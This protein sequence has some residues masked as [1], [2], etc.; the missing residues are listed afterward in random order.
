MLAG[1]GSPGATDG[2]GLAATFNAPGALA[3]V[4]R[5]L[6]VADDGNRALRRL[7][8]DDITAPVTTLATTLTF[9]LGLAAGPDAL[10]ASGA[11]IFKLTPE[12]QATRLAD[13]ADGPRGLAL[14]ANGNLLV[15]V[16]TT[17]QLKAVGVA[18]PSFSLRPVAGDASDPLNQPVA[19][20]VN[21]TE[22]YVACAGDGRIVLAQAT[23]GDADPRRTSTFASGFDRPAALAF[24][25][26]L[27]LVVAD[28]GRVAVAKDGRT[29]AANLGHPGGLAWDVAQRRLYVADTDHHVIRY[30]A[31]P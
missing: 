13:D 1:T 23:G 17:H 18:A 30:V 22:A 14:T 19:V 8:L 5:Y 12:G 11:G 21:G 27:G 4:G 26:G 9:P 16:P 31:I 29:L 7:Y 25:D 10:Y 20:A 28:A 2:P 24:V 15:A 3:L 6:F